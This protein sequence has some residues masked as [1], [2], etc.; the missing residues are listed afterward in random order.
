MN[1]LT[2]DLDF[3]TQ[4]QSPWHNGDAFNFLDSRFLGVDWDKTLS[5]KI[6]SKNIFIRPSIASTGKIGLQS[7]LQIQ[8]GLVNA[9]L[10]VDLW[11]QVPDLVKSGDL[12]TIKSGF[13]LDNAATFS[14]LSPDASYSLDAIFGMNAEASIAGK[15]LFK[16]SQFDW[17]IFDWNLPEKTTDLVDINA[18][19]S[20]I[21][22][23][24]NDFGNIELSLPKIDTTGSLTA[25][26]TL[27]SSGSDTFLEAELDLDGIATTI[28]QKVGV[29][30]PPLEKQW[31]KEFFGGF[32]KLGGGYNL[33]DVDI[34]PELNF[35]QDFNL[36]TE[37]LSGNLTLENGDVLNF[38]IG[39]DLTFAVPDG[40][41]D[42]L[43]LDAVLDLDTDFTNTTT[44]GYDVDLGLEALSL[45]GQVKIDFKRLKDIDR[46]FSLGPAL[47]KRYNLLDGDIIDVYD[48]T[49]ELGGL[50]SQTLSFNIPV[51][52]GTKPPANSLTLGAS[53]D[54]YIRTDLDI[55]RNDNYGKQH[56]ISVGTS[57]GGGGIPFGHPDAIRSLVRFDFDEAFED[58]PDAISKATL[59]LTIQD[60]SDGSNSDRYT[61][62]VHHIDPLTGMEN[63]DEGYGE[64]GTWNEG[65]GFEGS[66]APSGAVD[67]D[68]AF[69]VAWMG[70][71]VDGEN[72]ETQPDFDSLIV[73]S[74]TIDRN[75]HTIGDVIRWDVTPLVRDWLD[76]TVPNHGMMLVDE[77]QNPDNSFRAVQFG[78]R[79]G[80]SSGLPN[81]VAE[82][83]LIL[84]W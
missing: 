74:A 59:E 9:S 16:R 65:N 61:V 24:L 78:S 77:T 67:P 35:S 44:L 18:A 8:G 5:Q 39:Q 25:P 32:I 10:P 76:G 1:T 17:K 60:F 33:L 66:P 26:N 41:G 13:A 52:E 68:T 29:P 70:G 83:T 14:T 15:A 79:E 38:E 23:P 53:A 42:T 20:D 7:D 69:G 3:T 47:K 19:G 56:F 6:G 50:N 81:A 73:A 62:D 43:K 84:E 48:R 12:V 27:S 46:S 45:N 71:G 36:T 55:R 49:F 40:V 30:V 4:D 54:T 82:P 34:L 28:L 80:L 22:I 2:F 11:I 58:P 37:A 75:V 64:G 72:N 63:G 57:R 51:E 31:S 21:K